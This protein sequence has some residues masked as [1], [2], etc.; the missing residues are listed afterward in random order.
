MIGQLLAAAGSRR[1]AFDALVGHVAAASVDA[2]RTLVVDR[3]IG[4]GPAE[5]RGYIRGRGG[6]ILRRQ[7]RLTVRRHTNAD[8]TW[9]TLVAQ[10]AS[11]RVAAQLLREFSAVMVR[12]SQRRAA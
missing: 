11:D 7:A 2:V 8:P 10:R 4:M 12:A 9:E 1:K 6:R 5:A 3:V